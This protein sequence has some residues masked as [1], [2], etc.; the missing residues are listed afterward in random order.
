M[1]RLFIKATKTRVFKMS[2]GASDFMYLFL[3]NLCRCA[4]S[5]TP[6]VLNFLYDFSKNYV[7]N[8]QIFF[9]CLRCL[10]TVLP[11]DIIGPALILSDLVFL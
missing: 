3:H 11:M 6:S 7:V 10:Q 5:K 9:L 1:M 2:N 8:S 4:S